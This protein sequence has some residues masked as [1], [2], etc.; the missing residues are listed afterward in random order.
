MP[1]LELHD[2]KAE[3]LAPNVFRITATVVN[4][5]YLP[6]MPAMGKTSRQPRSVQVAIEPPAGGRVLTGQRR[7]QIEPL[8]GSGGK[9]ELSWTVVVPAQ[10]GSVEL[11]AWSP[12][13]GVVQ[14]SVELK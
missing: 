7:Q 14:T 5:G 6:T 11:R 13:V 10:A 2:V 9:I 8:S 3:R 12:S 4:S 1:K